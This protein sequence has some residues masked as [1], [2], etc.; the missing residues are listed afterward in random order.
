MQINTKTSYWGIYELCNLVAESS[1]A[2]Q[3]LFTCAIFT[4]KSFAV[5]KYH[6]ITHHINAFYLELLLCEAKQNYYND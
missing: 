4:G 5:A 3:K 2:H 6:D 1:L